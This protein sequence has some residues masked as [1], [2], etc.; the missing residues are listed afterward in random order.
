MTPV[1]RIPVQPWMTQPVL[2]AVM[3]AL[4]ADRSGGR[5][6]PIALFVGGCVR[7]ALLGRPVGEV[8]IATALLPEDVTARLAA[9]G[10]RAIPT[11]IEH[12]T[13]T[14]VAEGTP[15]E[16]TTLR[17]DVNPKGRHADVAF[18]DDWR[19][20]AERR[21]LTMNAL[22]LS[23]EGDVYDPVGGLA[24][25]RAGHVRFVG[26]AERRIREDVLRLLRFFRFHAHYGRVPPDPEGL[27]A[28]GRLAHLL[29]TLSAE[30][31]AKET[32]RLLAAPDPLP[33]LRL[34]R[35]AGV[36]AVLLP[37]AAS[38]DL[39]AALVTVEGVSDG[40]DAV[41]RLAA[42]LGA[43]ADTADSVA[44]RLRLST[45][46]RERLAD[47][48]QPA[49]RPSPEAGERAARATLYRCGPATWR[50]RVLLAWAASVAAG[51]AQH[52]RAAEGWRALLDLPERWAVPSPPVRGADVLAL[53]VAPGP[54]VGRL[55]AAVERW[56]IEGDFAA[57]REDCLAKLRELAGTG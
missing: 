10:I 32:L 51:A 36:L 22:F 11:G 21:D 33:A 38:L 13:V 18:T 56:W 43:D 25:L 28:C 8:D 14:A 5:E 6:A 1:L 17:V 57:G 46:E 37:E 26:E 12:G 47:M 45:R 7:D 34:M 15:F 41:R 31:V 16:I 20:D 54:E 49:G 42:L 19:A 23:P 55:V 4:A 3:A 52:R 29:P 2:R 53:G 30:R 40:G 9:A 50:D 35:E 39:V 24:D 48:L 27:A 44:I